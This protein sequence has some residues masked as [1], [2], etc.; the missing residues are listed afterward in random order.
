LKEDKQ[1]D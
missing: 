1:Y